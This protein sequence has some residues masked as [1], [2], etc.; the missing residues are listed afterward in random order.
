M[1]ATYCVES[2]NELGASWRALGV[3]RAEIMRCPENMN[4]YDTEVE[5]ISE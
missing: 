1:S 5:L 4:D 3:M 2:D